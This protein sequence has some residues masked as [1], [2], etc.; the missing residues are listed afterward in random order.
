MKTKCYII[1]REPENPKSHYAV[2]GLYFYDNSVIERAKSLKPSARGEI[3]ITDLNMTYLKRGQAK[4]RIA[5]K[6]FCMAR[7]R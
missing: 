4:G 2:P 6:R 1:R 7:Y 5:R 3:E